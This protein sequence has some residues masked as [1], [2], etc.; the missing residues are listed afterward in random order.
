M[1]NLSTP[2]GELQSRYGVVVVGSGYGG[3][4]AAHRMAAKAAALGAA[5]KPRFSVCV[6]ERGLEKR[7][8]EYPSSLGGALR[9]VQADT[10]IGHIGRRTGLFD[11]RVN[12]DVSVLVGCGLGGTSLINAGVMLPP[13]PEVLKSSEWPA[14][15][16][17]DGLE[18]EFREVERMLRVQPWPLDVPLTK[19]ARLRDAATTAGP[20]AHEVAPPLAVSFQT[21]VNFGVQQ[22]R[23]VLCGDCMTGCNHSAKNTVGM[24]YL[25]A[26][27]SHG[28][29]IFCGVQVRTIEPGAGDAWRLRIRIMDRAWRRFGNQEITIHAGMVFLAAGTLGST[30]ILLRSRTRHPSLKLSR[31]LGRRFSGNGDAMAFGYNAPERVDGIGYGRSVPRDAAVGPTIAGML[32]ERRNRRGVWSGQGVLIQEGAIPGALGPILRFAAPVMARLTHV[33]SDTSFDFRFRHLWRELDS[34]IRGVRHGALART[35]TF[36]VMSRD[37]GKGVLWLSRDRIRIA[38]PRAGHQ[39]VFERIAGRLAQLAR[40]MKARYLINPFWSRLFGRRLMTV[41]PLGGCCLGDTAKTGV[42]NAD[43]C[44]FKAETGS[45]VHDTLRVCDGSIIPAPLGTNPALTIAALAERISAKAPVPLPAWH[46]DQDHHPGRIQ[47]SVPGLHYAERLRG[48]MQ[49]T[50][51]R[52]RLELTL[53]ISAENLDDLL[54]K[55][56]H[57]AR[58]VG[59][60]RTP[61]LP[62]HQSFTVSDG[63]LHLF[64]DD[65]RS[66]DTKLLVYQ[67]KLTSGSAEVDS[68]RRDLWLRGHKRIN[69]DTLRRGTWRAIARLPL[70]VYET[71]PGKVEPPA[72]DPKTGKRDP[73]A[74]ADFIEFC[75]ELEQPRPDS[76]TAPNAGNGTGVVRSS[77]SDAIRLV[78][79]MD[80]MYEQRLSQRLRLKFR[81]V[82]YFAGL[83]F[84]ARAWPLQR[85]IRADPF[86]RLRLT[87]PGHIEAAKPIEDRRPDGPPRFRLTRYLAADVDYRKA[88]PVILAP[89]F[90]MSSD[91]F[92]VGTPSDTG[93][94]SIVEF[95]C[96]EGYQV[97]LLDY[98]GSD[99]IDASLSQFTLDELVADFCDAIGVVN[100]RTNQNVR[101]IAHCVASLTMLMA[102]L[103]GG[104]TGKGVT[105]LESV[106]LSQS[107]AFIDHPW[108]NRL[109][110]RLRLPEM[111]KFLRFRPVLTAD[112][113]LRS[114]LGG[115]LLD[116]MLRFYPTRER[117]TSGVCRRLL[118]LYGEV[119]RHD[120]LDLVT[121]ELMYDMFDRANLTTLQHLAKMIRRGRIVD[122]QGRDVYLTKAAGRKVTVPITLIQGRGNRLF[123]PAGAYRTHAWL[124]ANGGCGDRNRE[125]FSL[126]VI[127]GHGHL[128]TFIGKSASREVFPIIAA[129][130]KQME[131]KAERS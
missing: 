20:A 39:R 85:A 83:L 17:H 122:R 120:Q 58:I 124:V 127:P 25:P 16:Q 64:V 62:G 118:L 48:W 50:A 76:P 63:V 80:V 7:P 1:G 113:D 130:L 42:V 125:M 114:R 53:H 11:F 97:W 40:A 112:Y 111:L 14:A 108:S 37:D 74:T 44:V 61:D 121:H 43:G 105:G 41:H 98:R 119:V 70:V 19:V 28:A 31:T 68:A 10:G 59:L 18:T 106:I 21:R 8:G 45:E 109:K 13:L 86:N 27:A 29:A 91:A 38:W 23:C 71:D 22:Q 128:D 78:L 30:E 65:P 32:D 36:L 67:L 87:L 9:E 69:L 46:S 96:R 82:R 92:L 100:D 131:S 107:F 93:P 110:A 2:I 51:G 95:L 60:A 99:R 34:V 55:P 79:S 4:I 26:A 66:V 84:Q 102:L 104:K 52:T 117:C 6:L 49:C 116:R 3:A 81:F 5:G 94:K 15:L 123:R 77:F 89:G 72:H 88:R 33:P 90:G 54:Q 47:P 56:Q 129:S 101:V 126:R 103:R 12:P 73:Q 35:M 115:R 57:K 24:N 75:D